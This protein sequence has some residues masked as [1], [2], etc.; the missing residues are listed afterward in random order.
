MKI[1]YED[2]DKVEVPMSPLIDCVFL[3]LIFFLV[4]T[5]MKKWEKQIPLSLPSSTSSLSTVQSGD[6]PIV[7]SVDERNRIY[8]VVNVDAYSGEGTYV[9]ITD[10]SGFLGQLKQKYGTEIAIDVS[11]YRTVAVDDVI[12]VFDACQ[13]AGFDQTRVR[14]GSKPPS[15]ELQ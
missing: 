4:T 10:L 5:M 3:L 12:N 7:L 13:I 6:Q 2:D 11:A 9:P 15:D 14:L 8:Q 1:N